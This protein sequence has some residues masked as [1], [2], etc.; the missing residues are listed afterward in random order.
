MTSGSR[1]RPLC[2]RDVGGADF[3]SGR[4]L[5]AEVTTLVAAN[6]PGWTARR[7]AGVEVDRQGWGAVDAEAAVRSALETR[8]LDTT[9]SPGA[10]GFL[11]ER[12]N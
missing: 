8:A 4:D 3:V 6:T 7:I 11:G 1:G 12:K 5:E 2:R 9:A 10:K